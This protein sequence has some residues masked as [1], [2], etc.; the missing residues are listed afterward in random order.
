MSDP[1]RS[2]IMSDPAELTI[3]HL[4]L[5]ALPRARKELLPVLS[6]RFAKS[7]TAAEVIWRTR[8]TQPT[9]RIACLR[10]QTSTDLTRDTLTLYPPADRITPR[11]PPPLLCSVHKKTSKTLPPHHHQPHFTPHHSSLTTHHRSSLRHHAPRH[12]LTKCNS[13]LI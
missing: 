8:R 5:S 9:S 7:A 6:L 11:V 13:S 1:L 2:I 4:C 10:L 12:H 3:S